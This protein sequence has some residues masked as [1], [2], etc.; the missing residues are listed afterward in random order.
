M[1]VAPE[2]PLMVWAHKYNIWWFA[3]A[4]VLVSGVWYLYL[5]RNKLARMLDKTGLLLKHFSARKNIVKAV[6][7]SCAIICLFLA[8]LHPQWGLMVDETEQRG[9]DLVIALD[10]SR[11]MLAQDVQPDRLTCA[12]Q[13]IMRIAQ[14][15]ET[16]RVALMIFS[17][18]ARIYC[19]L[20][21]DID[22]IKS[23]LENFDHTTLSAGT[24]CLD[25]PIRSTIAQCQRN[26]DRKHNILLMV[27]DGEDFSGSL[28]GLQDQARSCGLTIL[29]TGVGTTQGAP[30]PLYDEKKQRTGYLKDAHDRVVISQLNKSVLEKLAKNT[31][32]LAL[33]VEKSDVSVDQLITR[34]KQFDKELQGTVRMPS[35]KEQHPWF[36]LVSFT[37]L[38]IE[39]VL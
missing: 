9:R 2:I 20:T 7:A 28:D 1:I 37:C 8:L 29:V 19:P 17:E 30:I 5:Y 3:L 14:A 35:L 31:G 13:V 18:K 6:L 11:S 16:D 26:P 12:K 32:G 36:L 4:A 33:F 15:L 24:T 25:Q 22:L 27:S 38:L 21:K 10:V 23:F 39:W 34:I